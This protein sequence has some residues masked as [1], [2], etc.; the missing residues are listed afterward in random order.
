MR[1]VFALPLVFVACKASRSA[2]AAPLDVPHTIAVQFPD[3]FPVEHTCDGADTP[4]EITYDNLP[5]NTKLVAIVV[6]DPDA[7]G[8]LFTHWIVW[9][10][11]PHGEKSGTTG[12]NDFG[13]TR[14]NGPCPPSGTHHYHVKVIALDGP[15][16]LKEGADRAAFDKALKGRALADG[17]A[18]ATYSRKVK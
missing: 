7:P 13:R 15:L 4:P 8:G 17:E 11:T 18:V 9:N 6:D 1:V 10:Q 5:P 12:K 16:D 14:W 2:H 3:A